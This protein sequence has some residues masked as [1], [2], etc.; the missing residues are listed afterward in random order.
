MQKSSTTEV[1]LSRTASALLM[2]RFVEQRHLKIIKELFTT[3]VAQALD[4]RKLFM[5]MKRTRT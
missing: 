1:L 3:Q 5:Q 2:E 4:E